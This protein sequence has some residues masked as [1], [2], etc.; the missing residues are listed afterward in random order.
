ME[1][2][3][4]VGNRTVSLP[5][6]ANCNISISGI[7]DRARHNTGSFSECLSSPAILNFQHSAPGRTELIL[8]IW[9]LPPQHDNS[10]LRDLLLFASFS[11]FLMMTK[12][13]G[14]FYSLFPQVMKWLLL[15]VWLLANY[16]WSLIWWSPRP[17]GCS[18]YLRSESWVFSWAFRI[19]PPSPFGTV[20]K[21]TLTTSTKCFWEKCW[22]TT[23]ALPRWLLSGHSDSDNTA[24]NNFEAIWSSQ[25]MMVSVYRFVV[26]NYH[27]NWKNI[28]ASFVPICSVLVYVLV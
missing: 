3:D 27:R 24:R 17:Y 2:L 20:T 5:V 11:A 18:D 22:P 4:L 1:D 23:I 7:Q 15:G 8:T 25:V 6:T 10:A 19:M 16:G 14:Q 28:S 13:Q 9:M 12:S 21:L 26:L